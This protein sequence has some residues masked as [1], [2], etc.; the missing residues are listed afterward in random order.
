MNHLKGTS[1]AKMNT[2]CSHG[3]IETETVEVT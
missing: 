3:T 2:C 1:F